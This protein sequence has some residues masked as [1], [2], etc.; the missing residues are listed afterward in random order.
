[1]TIQ[2]IVESPDFSSWRKA[3]VDQHCESFSF[4]VSAPAR[5]SFCRCNEAEVLLSLQ[6]E[7]RLEYTAIHQAYEEGIENLLQQNLPKEF[8]MVAFMEALPA[9]LEGPGQDKEEMGQAVTLLSN[10]S[11]F[12]YFKDM[13]LY[14]KQQREERGAEYL[15]HAQSATPPQAGGLEA[16][17]LVELCAKLS[18]AENELDSWDTLVN[19]KI[20]A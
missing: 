14:E 9:Y 10:V 15:D 8:D 2:A 16:N 13:M 4:E 19:Q 6:D 5:G 12:R 7:N 20:F 3:F 18:V 11:D 1:M 17:E